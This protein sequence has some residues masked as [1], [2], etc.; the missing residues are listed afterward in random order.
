MGLRLTSDR[1]HAM[2]TAKV[3][4]RVMG[5]VVMYIRPGNSADDDNDCANHDSV[6]VLS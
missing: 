4:D 1:L 2:N 6:A 3:A 5:L